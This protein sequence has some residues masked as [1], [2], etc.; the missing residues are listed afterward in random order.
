MSEPVCLGC[1]DGGRICGVAA[2]SVED[3][4]AYLAKRLERLAG[5]VAVPLQDSIAVFDQRAH[6][7]VLVHRDHFRQIADV[8][9]G[10]SKQPNNEQDIK[11]ILGLP[12]SSSRSRRRDLSLHIPPDCIGS[13]WLD[14]AIRFAHTQREGNISFILHSIQRSTAWADVADQ[15]LRAFLALRSPR[16][17][18]RWQYICPPPREA[19][20]SS[21]LDTLLRLNVQLRFAL[22][23]AAGYPYAL[24]QEAEA[25]TQQMTDYG[26][27]IP[28]L[29]YYRNEV[30][31]DTACLL[32]RTL[33]VTRLSGI[34]VA[35]FFASPFVDRADLA[36]GMDPEGYQALVLALYENQAISDFLLDPIEEMENRIDPRGTL[37]SNFLIKSGGGTVSRFFKVPALV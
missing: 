31:V 16:R 2:G 30:P 1:M 10:D 26:L 34:G 14:I 13:D 20:G 37:Q 6:H 15:L 17:N 23:P 29:Y 3:E 27:R 18:L 12:R 25:A 8:L 11:S 9:D 28:F 5:L 33:S 22:G 7:L 36:A 21:D 19:A 35:P 24:G 4:L 32:R